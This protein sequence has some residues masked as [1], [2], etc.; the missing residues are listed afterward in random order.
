M[1]AKKSTFFIGTIIVIAIALLAFFGLGEIKGA[2]K[3][4]FGID[5]RGGVEAIF[6]PVNLDRVP[7]QQEL[8]SARSV[9]ESRLDAKNILDREVT[10]DKVEGHI[11]VRFPWK[12]DEADFNPEASI[13]ELGETAELTFKDP[14]GNVLIEG[15]H[16]KHSEVARDPNT[17][18]FVVSLSFD[19][20]GAKLFEE[21]TGKLIG[22]NMGIFMDENII[23]NPQVQK[24]ISG[25]EA[26]IN[27][28][29]NKEE[30]TA[31]SEKINAGALP[32]SMTTTNHN[33]IS[34][35]LGSGALKTMMEAGLIAFILVCLFMIFFYRLP[36]VIS[37]IALILQISLQLL[38]LSAPQFTL[39]LPGIAG[40]ILSIGMAVDA[41]IIISERICEELRKGYSIRKAIQAG[42]A[43]AFSSVLDGNVTSAIVAVILMIF[44]SGA[45]LSFG[46]TL[47]TG[48][49][50]NFIAA[51]FTSHK[52]LDSIVLFKG[53]DNLKLY[54][55]RKER[56]TISFYKKR[57]I[58]FSVSIG[59]MVI[60]LVF[61]FINGVKLDTQFVGGAILKYT[62]EGDIDV[63]TMGNTASNVIDRPTA[64]QITTDPAT[65]EQKLVLTLAGN[66]GIT[67]DEQ[68]KLTEAIESEYSN[69]NINLSESFVVEPYIGQK[70]LNNSIIAI[71][72]SLVLIIAYVWIRFSILSGLSAGVTAV[73]ALAHDIII[74]FFIFVLFKIPL[75]DAYVAV[76][77]T[78]I[79]YSINDT[80]VLYDRIR[81]NKKA[82]LGLSLGDLVSM[83]ITQTL[84][85]TIKTSV[86][87]TICMTI[88]LVFSILYG[89]TSI[90]VFS[91][92][93]L[94]GLICG[95]Y[96][97][98][99][100]AGPLWVSWQEFK[101][102]RSNGKTLEN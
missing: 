50:L 66:N 78:I 92:P 84:G 94:F 40:I 1:N 46:Y 54:G 15:K 52:L 19:S 83:S 28:M 38:A 91:L 59:M 33:S 102:R 6:K 90:K 48:I 89:I 73:I 79:G 26:I 49:F 68:L 71:V 60:G 82:Q 16:I 81:E 41:N 29:E 10:V 9:I 3:M 27:G 93:M 17:G 45:M 69:L 14:D 53:M 13:A 18:E 34:P 37:C 72:L 51:I 67:P 86:T 55:V 4:R 23:S 61:S 70:A 101:E 58:A 12:S 2:N 99:F 56:K 97:T 20:E 100:I 77:L 75:N 5:I 85:R 7:T 63:D 39:T 11:I 22:K 25:G 98:I 96:S 42:Y 36:G 74:V 76:S 43:N 57:W 80:I 88:I 8:D 47:L 31:L 62:F 30:A 44:G 87:T 95:C 35:T 64:A 65:G 32:F 21:A 24:K